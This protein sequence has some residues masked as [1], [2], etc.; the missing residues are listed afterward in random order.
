MQKTIIII[1]ISV[2]ICGVLLFL[3]VKRVLKKKL[4]YHLFKNNKQKN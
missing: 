2:A 3:Y 4:E 1:V